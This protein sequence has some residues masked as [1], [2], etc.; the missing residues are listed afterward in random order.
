MHNRQTGAAHV[1]MMFFLLIL[2]LFLGATGFAFMTNTRNSEL[3]TERNTARAEAETLRKRDLLIEHY[4]KDLGDV[5]QK[6]GAYAGRDGQEAIYG[7]AT[8]TYPGIS[9]PSEIRAAMDAALGAA[10]LSAASGIENVLGS[11]VTRVNQLNQRIKD[12]EAERDKALAEKGEVDRKF[13]AATT[14]ASAKAREFGQNLDQARTDFESAKQDKDNRIAQGNES[15][16]AKQDE[17]STEKE[18]AAA[19]EKELNREIAKHQ[20]QN[21]AL[22]ARETLRKTAD[23]SDGFIVAARAGV[24][25]AFINLGRKDL[26]QP[27]TVFRIKSPTSS[28]VKGYAQVTRVEDVR[29][30]VA[31]MDFVDPIGDFARDGDQIY[32]DF[33]SPRVTRTIYLMGR[34]SAPYN[35][36]E[37][38][39]LLKR[40]G[41]NVVDKMAPGVDTV[42][43]GGDPV[44]EAGDGFASVQESAEFKL[45]SELR[46]EFAYLSSVRDLIKL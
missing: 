40:L 35:K 23:V 32:N 16:R 17:L 29:A 3:I 37:L 21:S 12:I 36:P 5:L 26:L 25:T 10:G 22:I 39:N 4:I 38:T 11:M 34:F 15:L 19:K 9:K 33:Y 45:A 43:L 7:G 2:V 14:D 6:P 41:N 28:K 31:L 46:V 8:M 27:G 18:R 1:P 13:Q 44:N 20:M 24:P 42:I 30:E